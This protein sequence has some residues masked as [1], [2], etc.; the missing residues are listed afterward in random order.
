MTQED[1]N[2]YAAT[3]AAT[4][5]E[6][7][8][9]AT[10]HARCPR[11]SLWRLSLGSTTRC[12]SCGATVELSRKYVTVCAVLGLVVVLW[13]LIMSTNEVSMVPFLAITSVVI[14]CEILIARKIPVVVVSSA[15][16]KRRLVEL[17]LSILLL[18]LIVA[19]IGFYAR[20]MAG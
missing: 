2:P 11:P 10:D 5:E 7:D 20:Y 12:P 4:L 19:A 16:K 6:S 17:M 13:A 14:A 1:A 15:E 8:A 3:R 18:V 9:L